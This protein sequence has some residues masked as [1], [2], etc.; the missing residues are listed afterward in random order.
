MPIDMKR[1]KKILDAYFASEQFPKDVA[2]WE[3][4]YDKSLQETGIDPELRTA[5]FNES[6]FTVLSVTYADN[7][8]GRNPSG[9]VVGFFREKIFARTGNASAFGFLRTNPGTRV[10][11]ATVSD[12][13]D[14]NDARVLLGGVSRS[15]R[16]G[17]LG[18]FVLVPDPE[19]RQAMIDSGFD[20]YPDEASLIGDFCVRVSG[21]NRA[22]A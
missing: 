6:G 2:E 17:V 10:V 3:E 1:A 4:K 13:R 12:S 9:P 15:R 18:M 14:A 16:L 22:S 11:I 7:R 19:L 20:A 21:R 8:G 5:F